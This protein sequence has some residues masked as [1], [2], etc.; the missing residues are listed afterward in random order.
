MNF[1]CGFRGGDDHS[2]TDTFA[3]PPPPPSC[4]SSVHSLNSSKTTESKKRLASSAVGK[5]FSILTVARLSSIELCIEN[6]EQCC[7]TSLTPQA[8]YELNLEATPKAAAKIY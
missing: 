5:A 8:T 6:L 7:P 2:A 4:S 3:V 1:T